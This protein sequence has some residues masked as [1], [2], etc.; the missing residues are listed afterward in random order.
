MKCRQRFLNLGGPQF[1]TP[2]SVVH[3]CNL[4]LSVAQIASTQEATAE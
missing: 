4:L 2:L 3:L 1:M